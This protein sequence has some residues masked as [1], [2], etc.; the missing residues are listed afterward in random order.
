MSKKRKPDTSSEISSTDVEASGA[1]IAAMRKRSVREQPLGLVLTVCGVV[2]IALGLLSL[3]MGRFSVPAGDVMNILLS[4]ITGQDGSWTQNE[5]NVVINS[6]LPRVIA[7][8]LVGA[9]LALSGAAYQGVFQNPLVSPDILGVS[10]GAC[11]GAAI[12]ILL[13]L[14]T[15]QTQ[16]FAFFGGLLAVWITVSIPKLMHR[17]S[18][19]VMVL[20][21]VIVGGFMSSIIGLLKYV[22]DPDTQLAEITYWQLGSIAKV[23][24]DTLAYTAPAMI[25]AGIVILAMRW[26]INLLSLGEDEAR[27]LGVNLKRE[28][29][30]VI[31]A[32]TVLTACA[33]SLS[34]TIGW[35][36][37]IIPHVAR[38]I[39][40]ED[41]KRLIPTVALVAAAFLLLVDLIARCLTGYEIPLGILTGLVGAPIFGYILVKQKDV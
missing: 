24:Y 7:A 32:S 17:H 9:A 6:R 22:A 28:R 27:S 1:E 16:I 21:G 36:G 19:I 3:C 14:N 5:Y 10:Y 30:I 41:N 38:R 39:V 8:I 26:R 35:V 40:G 23:N 2:V 11:V 13:Y 4:P 29:G 20:S 33:V 15:W 18:N 34:G 12:S 37:L 31:V 25:V